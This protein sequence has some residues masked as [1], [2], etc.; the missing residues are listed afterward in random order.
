MSVVEDVDLEIARLEATLNDR[1]IELSGLRLEQAWNP[2]LC[3]DQDRDGKSLATLEIK[4]RAARNMLYETRLLSGDQT[5]VRAFLDPPN[6]SRESGTAIVT[7]KHRDKLT[8]HEVDNVNATIL[9]EVMQVELTGSE[10]AG[11][12]KLGADKVVGSLKIPL[13]SLYSQR[14][15]DRWHEL[16][17]EGSAVKGDLLLSC[18]FHRSR[19]RWVTSRGKAHCV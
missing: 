9:V 1:Q 4:V 19:V 11:Y 17:R 13:S 8:F 18:Q 14:P 7:K 3:V 6:A 16:E 15:Q 12:G 5:Y 10:S 2:V